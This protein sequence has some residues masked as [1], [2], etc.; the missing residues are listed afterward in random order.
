ML[1]LESW[2]EGQSLTHGNLEVLRLL[3]IFNLKKVYSKRERV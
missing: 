1:F 2:Q 3:V